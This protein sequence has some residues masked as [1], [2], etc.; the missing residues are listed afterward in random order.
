MNVSLLVLVPLLGL[1]ILSFSVSYGRIRIMLFSMLPCFILMFIFFFLDKYKFN[2]GLLR[3]LG[4]ST[5]QVISAAFRY[6]DVYI[7]NIYLAC[8]MILFL[9]LFFMVYCSLRI[10]FSSLLPM[11]DPHMNKVRKRTLHFLCSSLF[12]ITSGMLVVYMTSAMRCSTLVTYGFLNDIFEWFVPV[13]VE[14]L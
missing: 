11:P 2:Y 14:S 7:E 8:G 13:R 3:G 9:I 6:S 1:L 5:Y 12:F 4:I 10:I